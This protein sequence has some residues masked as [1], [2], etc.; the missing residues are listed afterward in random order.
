MESDQLRA[1]G[2][3]VAG[4]RVCESAARSRS[5]RLLR[6]TQVLRSVLPPQP[7]GR[8]GIRWRWAWREGWQ[9]SEAQGTAP[10]SSPRPSQRSL[11]TA[12]PPALFWE[13]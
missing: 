3:C 12:L 11:A 8:M 7:S 5:P 2:F 10:H 13:L 9:N 6:V 1:G 4:G